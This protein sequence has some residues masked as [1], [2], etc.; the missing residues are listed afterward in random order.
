MKTYVST[1][2]VGY[3]LL[4]EVLRELSRR[5]YS[6][7][8]ISS[9]HRPHP[10]SWQAIAAYAKKHDASV[11]LHNF[12]PP[13]PGDLMINLSNPDQAVRADV[14]AFL[15]SRIDLTRELGSDYYSFHGGFRVPYRLGIQTYQPG[16]RMSAQRALD[17]FV[18]ALDEVVAHAEARGVHV[19]VENHVVEWG[20]EDNVI[21]YSAKEF[22]LLFD[23][24][25]SEYLHLHLDVG[26]LSISSN[27]CGFDRHAFI[28]QFR[29][30]VMAAHVHDNDGT[31]DTH[32]GFGD[33][34]WFLKELPGLP[35]LRYVCLET[36]R[37]KQSGI[38]R[39]QVL[40]DAAACAMPH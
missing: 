28:H 37:Q 10:G 21:L 6:A 26:H 20:N 2:S 29:G 38:S 32:N 36:A 14:V 4:P 33:D 35:A 1:C 31:K 9:G 16:E 12:A 39:M 30:K 15:K 25:T 34:F 27:T 8:E 11:L 19:G 17:I 24:I 5:Q 13:E 7:I 23:T 22:Q 3:G 18:Q 40:L